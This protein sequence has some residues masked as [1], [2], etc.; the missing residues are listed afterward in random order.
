MSNGTSLSRRFEILAAASLATTM[1]FLPAS[2]RASPQESAEAPPAEAHGAAEGPERKG[3]ELVEELTYAQHPGLP[4]AASKIFFSKR[5]WTISGFGELAHIHHFGEKNRAS[6]DIELYDTNLYRFVVY[7]AYRPTDWLVLYAEGFAEVF[8]DGF[9]EVHYEVLPEVFADFLLTNPRDPEARKRGPHIGPLNAR[10]GFIQVPIGYINENDEPI[11]FYSVNRPEVERLVI[12]SQW[13]ELGAELYGKL[14][15][16]V[17]W[18]L[19]A[20][21]GVDGQELLGATWARRGRNPGYSFSSPA[22]AAQ[23]NVAPLE[24]LDLSVSGVAMESG[25]GRHIVVEGREQS[26]QARTG[27]VSGH[28]RYELDNWTVMVLA[29]AGYMA[30]TDQLYELTRRSDRGPQVL[31]ERTYGYY[32]EVGC[33]VLPYLRKPSGDPVH[34]PLYRSDEV[35]VPIFARYERLDT[36]ADI[37]ATLARRLSPEQPIYRSDLDLITVGVNFKPRRNLVLKAD[38]TFRR[39]RARGPGLAREGDQLELGLGFIF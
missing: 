12:P 24:H 30:D 9:D 34:S 22:I 16:H 17:E 32:V 15:R 8:Q 28:V 10:V 3:S 31:G 2:A 21:Q 23:I 38:Y 1:T 13:V 27:L 19:H 11:M 7:G 25:G 26:I 33:D 5:P 39:N 29:A 14:G 35:Q 4:P 36:H 37:D 20:F 6:G 18:L